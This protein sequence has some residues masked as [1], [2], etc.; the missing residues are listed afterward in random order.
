MEKLL[1]INR[2]QF[3]YHIDSYKYCQYLKN[4]FDITYI[5]FNNKNKKVRE[6]GVNVVYIKNTGSFLNRGLRFIRF[7]RHYI[8]KENYD[9]VFIVHFIMAFLVK[10]RLNQSKFILDIRTASVNNKLK[11]RLIEDLALRVNVLFFRRITIISKC[12]ML[13]LGISNKK[14]HIL[15]LGSDPI[16]INN[17]TFKDINLLYVGTLNGRSID[18]TVKGLAK[19]IDECDKARLGLRITYDIIGFGEKDEERQLANT[20]S[21]LNLESYIMFHGRIMHSELE[22]FFQ[23]TNIGVSFVPIENHYQ[24]QP[25]TKT[26]EYINSGLFCIATKTVANSN[27]ISKNNGILCN[28]SEESFYE[29]LMILNKIKSRIH[30]ERVRAT[31]NDCSWKDIVTNNLLQYLNRQ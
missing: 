28:D 24:C 30:S 2:A 25:P 3:G 19:F 17:K 11:V 22:P 29:A 4:K 10:I 15:P 27:L 7:C 13:K 21:E 1:I 18:K 16:S 12:L 26:Y 31:L 5:C 6:D 9:I 8:K 20:I 23:K 14:C